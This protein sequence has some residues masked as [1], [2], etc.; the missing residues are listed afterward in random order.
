VPSGES[1]PKI[2]ARIREDPRFRIELEQARA[3]GKS[4]SVFTGRVVG[5]GEPEFLPEDTDGAVA[6]AEEEGDTCP[7][8]GR[9]MA[10]CRSPDVK[11]TDLDVVEEECHFTMRIAQHTVGDKWR[12]KSPESRASTMLGTR[13]R[14]DR[15]PD[16]TAGLDLR[17]VEVD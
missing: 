9:P 12:G 6:L 4:H 2:R 13:F 15:E 16:W 8:C 3:Y 1:G 5:T 7:A 10:I 17:D 14:E 11:W